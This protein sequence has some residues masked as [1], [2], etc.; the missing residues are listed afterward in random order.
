M[1]IETDSFGEAIWFRDD[2]LRTH[3]NHF[4]NVLASR[5]DGVLLSD[6]F[7]TA[8]GVEIGDVIHFSDWLGN[9]TRGTVMGFVDHWPG[10]S[11]MQRQYVDGQVVEVFQPLIVA[12]LGH[13]QTQWEVRPYEIWMRTNTE[14]NTFFHDF[15]TENRVMIVEFTDAQA[16]LIESRSDPIL[17]GTNGVLTV[18]FIVTL[19]ICFTGF[20][21]YWILSIRSRVLQ[22]GIFR[23]MGMSMRSLIGLL[24][25]EQ[26]FITFTAIGLGALVGEISSRLFVPLIQMSYSAADQAIPLMIVTEAQDYR[27]LYV[28]V[29]TM[30]FICLIVLAAYISKIKI[31]QALKLGED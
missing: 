19:T 28:V 31:A 6:N 2:L 24:I 9:P 12:N 4:L 5:S 17:Q 15:V 25:N 8:N 29:G 1:A 22:F 3:I 30:I 13:L 18:G 14:T 27:N 16:D 7:R 21:I 20:L 23:A 26:F 10:F 11:P